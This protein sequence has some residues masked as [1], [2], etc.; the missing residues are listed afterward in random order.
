MKKTED[1]SKKW[2]DIPGS[3]I[4]RINIIK[5][6]ILPKGIYRFHAIPI[7]IPRTFFTELEQIILKF[8]W[9]HKRPQIT[10]AILRK[11]NKAGGITLPAFRLYSNQNSMVLTQKQ[12]HG[13]MEQNREPR[14]KPI[15][16]WS[17]NL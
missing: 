6:A 15:H 11:K 4:G 12:T 7:K 14:N 13:S 16:L 2:K 5:M 17:I 1:D 10:K 3:W 9:N 8:M